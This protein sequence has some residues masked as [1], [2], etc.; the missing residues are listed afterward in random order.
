MA[1]TYTASVPHAYTDGPQSATSAAGNPGA[2][3]TDS[4]GGRSAAAASLISDCIGSTSVAFI[5][6]R[7]ARKNP[8]PDPLAIAQLLWREEAIRLH[9]EQYYDLKLEHMYADARSMQRPR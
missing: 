7:P 5:E 3:Q 4:T 2:R 8:K 6:R 9:K 1:A